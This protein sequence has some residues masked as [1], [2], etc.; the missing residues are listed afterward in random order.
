MNHFTR[1]SKV[2]AREGAFRGCCVSMETLQEAAEWLESCSFISCGF[3][4]EHKLKA[5]GSVSEET[6]LAEAQLLCS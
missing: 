3:N 6:K 4:L 1:N 5:D 2:P